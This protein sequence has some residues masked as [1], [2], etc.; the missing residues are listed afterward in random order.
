MGND[1]RY[2][3]QM[4]FCGIILLLSVF[5]AQGLGQ[6]NDA[7]E[8]KLI[9]SPIAV[10]P[11]E[12]RK[13]GLGGTVSVLVNIDE[14]GSVL[15]ATDATGPDWVC[16][17]V[18]QPDVLALREAAIKAA[19]TTKFEPKIVD[20]KVIPSSTSL[21]IYFPPD[22]KKGGVATIGHMSP[23]AVL[24][25]ESQ[26]IPKPDF[27]KAGAAA[28]ASGPVNIQ[29]LIEVDGS[30]I[31]A[32]PTSGH[33]LLRGAARKAAC[34][35]RFSPTVFSGQPVRVSGNITYNFRPN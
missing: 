10:K 26:S 32:E 12:A 24:D 14:N 25:T 30:V 34:N 13:T 7:A 18:T 3:T 8:P 27:P 17:N 2:S 22:K 19:L 11:K 35:A 6:Q 9:N 28:K 31:S 29:I 20:G 33:P 16:P 5:A 4:R 23:A 15:S 21:T 1:L